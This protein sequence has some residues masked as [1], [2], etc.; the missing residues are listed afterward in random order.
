M[1]TM[2]KDMHVHASTLMDSVV[3]VAVFPTHGR[4]QENLST[5]DLDVVDWKK[6]QISRGI[7]PVTPSAAAEHAG[8]DAVPADAAPVASDA[9]DIASGDISVI[10]GTVASASVSAVV[11]PPVYHALKLQFKLGT[12]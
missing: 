2:P 5:T 4:A 10:D 12:C 8:N 7:R 6:T 1:D 3:S 9:G 11:S